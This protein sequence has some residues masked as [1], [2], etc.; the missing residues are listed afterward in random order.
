MMLRREID[1][2]VLEKASWDGT[3]HSVYIS[4]G[5]TADYGSVG[6]W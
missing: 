4:S 6:L 1:R 3:K 5:V 2:K